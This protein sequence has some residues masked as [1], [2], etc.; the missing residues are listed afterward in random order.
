MP[1]G[2][3]LIFVTNV[4]NKQWIDS[5]LKNVI[6]ELLLIVELI[7]V[8]TVKPKSRNKGSGGISMDGKILASLFRPVLPI[9]V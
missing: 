5:S 7:A 8:A 4:Q 3:S 2:N 9:V 6:S 1:V